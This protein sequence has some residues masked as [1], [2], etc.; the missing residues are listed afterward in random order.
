[1]NNNE[2]SETTMSFYTMIGV[3]AGGFVAVFLSGTYGVVPL[4]SSII[5]F[6]VVMI[7]LLLMIEIED[8]TLDVIKN[9]RQWKQSLRRA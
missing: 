2:S 9:I 7:V 5:G 3:V 8:M 4:G 6:G 1:M